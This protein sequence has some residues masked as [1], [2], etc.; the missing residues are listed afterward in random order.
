MSESPPAFVAVIEW[1]VQPRWFE[2][3]PRTRLDYTR[4]LHEIINRYPSLRFRWFDAEA[5]TGKFTDFALCEFDDLDT[6]NTLWGELRRHPFLATPF[7]HASRVLMGMQLDPPPP[8]CPIC[9]QPLKLTA[10][11]CGT[12]GGPNPLV[13]GRAGTSPPPSE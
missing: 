9:A 7:A 5:W 11:F 4:Q 10:R 2:L 12:C 1:Q 13:A 8:C 3:D 6:Y